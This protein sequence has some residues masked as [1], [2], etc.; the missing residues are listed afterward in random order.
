MIELGQILHTARSGRIIVK[1]SIAASGKKVNGLS[2]I[3]MNG[4]QIGKIQE[5]FGPVSSP[6][7]SIQPVREKLASIA[8]ATVFIHSEVSRKSKSRKDYARKAKKPGR[9]TLSQKGRFTER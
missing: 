8:G 5:I 4:R 1:I 6:Y 3:D 9:L 7:A 2:V